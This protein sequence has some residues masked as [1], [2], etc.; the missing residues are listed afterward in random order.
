MMVAEQKKTRQR[1][2]HVTIDV[3]RPEAGRYSA[4]IA[5]GAMQRT[6]TCFSPPP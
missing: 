1:R 6:E 2:V 4:A 3:F 5:I